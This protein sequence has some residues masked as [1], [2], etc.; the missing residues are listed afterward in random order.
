MW[1]CMCHYYYY[2]YYYYYRYYASDPRNDQ[3]VTW[4][5]GPS[6]YGFV[7]PPIVEMRKDGK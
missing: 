6:L 5:V 4:G 7:D 1:G 2:Y 3:S